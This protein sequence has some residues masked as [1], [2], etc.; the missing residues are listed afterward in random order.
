[1]SGS[2]KPNTKAAFDMTPSTSSTTDLMTLHLVCNMRDLF[3]VTLPYDSS[4]RDLYIEVSARTA[5][6]KTFFKLIHNY[7]VLT[8]NFRLLSELSI[9]NES[10]VKL[11]VNIQSGVNSLENSN[12][13]PA[14]KA[15]RDYVLR[16][17][18]KQVNDFFDAKH[19]LCIKVPLNDAVGILKFKL[20]EPMPQNADFYDEAWQRV[21]DMGQICQLHSVEEV[22]SNWWQGKFHGD[23]VPEVF[24]SKGVPGKTVD[25]IISIMDG[26]LK[27]IWRTCF[28]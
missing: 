13:T 6:S 1:M 19:G 8:D 21:K 9:R 7:Q 27:S 22:S 14:R 4:V 10:K 23:L 18:P 5:L 12:L 2:S 25:T 17:T 20:D 11:N 3:S 28:C 15:I 16:M 24:N 26:L